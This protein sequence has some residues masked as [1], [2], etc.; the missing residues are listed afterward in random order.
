MLAA[1]Q[2]QQVA[3]LL[4][5]ESALTSQNG[6]RQQKQRNVTSPLA[7]LKQPLDPAAAHDYFATDKRPVVLFDG[8][9]NL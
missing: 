8:V 5:R 4:T 6:V 1:Q 2:W 9:C 7:A 3:V